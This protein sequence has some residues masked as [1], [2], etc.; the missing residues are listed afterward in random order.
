MLNM[1]IEQAA[2]L[3]GR[4][5]YG[6]PVP[7][8]PKDRVVEVENIVADDAAPDRSGSERNLVVGL[9]IAQI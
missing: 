4:F 7:K 3:A 5:P 1:P 9:V 2:G 6:Q 8:R